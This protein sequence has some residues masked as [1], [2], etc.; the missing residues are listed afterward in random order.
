VNHSIVSVVN[1]APKV[2]CQTETYTSALMHKSGSA[3]G[4]VGQP[5]TRLQDMQLWG[6]HADCASEQQSCLAQSAVIDC[7]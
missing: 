5:V 4:R 7:F 2:I 6:E 1:I 3:S